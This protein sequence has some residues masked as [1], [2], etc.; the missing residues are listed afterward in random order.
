M[1]AMRSALMN[2]SQLHCSELTFFFSDNMMFVKRGNSER[3]T[4]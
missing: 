3:T 1:A 4:D 2:C